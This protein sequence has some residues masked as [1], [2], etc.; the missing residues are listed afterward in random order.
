M[1]NEFVK[2]VKRVRVELESKGVEAK[3]VKK[4]VTR[5]LRR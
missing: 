5:E 3:K 1:M 4:V 2:K